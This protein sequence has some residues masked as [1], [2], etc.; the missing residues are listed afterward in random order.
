MLKKYGK[1]IIIVV[2]LLIIGAFYYSYSSRSETSTQNTIDPRM[3]MEVQKGNVRKTIIA[4]G[5]IEP[6]DEED[7]TFPS[8]SGGS[9]KVKKIYVQEGEKVEEGQLLME[10]DETEARLNYLQ[11]ENAYNRARINGSRN[12]IE[13]ARLNL[14]LAKNELE[15]LD[16]KAPFSGIITDIYLE[17]G[18]YYTSGVAATIKDVS[19]LQVEVNIEES[20]IPIIEI[21]QP[22]EVSLP[23]LPDI[24]LSGR[25]HKLGN[26]ADNT[27]SIVTLPVTVLLDEVDYDIKLGVSAELDIIVGEVKDKVVIPITALV[28]DRGQDAVVK[29]IDGKTR[30]VPVE[31]GL[32][33]GLNVAIESGLEPGDKI[34]INTFRQAPDYGNSSGNI[35]MGGVFM[36]GPR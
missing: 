25:V 1:V 28:N 30:Q 3:V 20:D 14:E 31:T 33:D 18:S 7:L 5:F 11:R 2:V 12:E 21:G 26:E 35:R 9:V 22:V 4:E 16:L 15:N 27:S 17:E 24:K 19:R 32:T 23:S 10:L 6:V 13:E 36:G 29:V 34:L 8:R